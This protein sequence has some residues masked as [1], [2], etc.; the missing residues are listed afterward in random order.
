M[1][2][3]QKTPSPHHYGI[4]FLKMAFEIRLSKRGQVVA[5]TC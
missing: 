4:I 3:L 2:K 5:G 1:A